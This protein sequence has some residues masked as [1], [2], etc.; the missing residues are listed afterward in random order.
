MLHASRWQ[1]LIIVAAFWTS[2]LSLDDSSAVSQG[3]VPEG[4]GTAPTSNT[5][6]SQ[7]AKLLAVR[8]VRQP[9]DFRP[10]YYAKIYSF[11]LYISL[12]MN[13]KSYCAEYTTQVL[14]EIADVSSAVGSEVPVSVRKKHVTITTPVGRHL[15][16]GLTKGS[17]CYAG[18]Q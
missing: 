13:Q 14:E 15:K 10:T 18:P 5:E 17:E 3:I 9:V 7:K 11:T 8:K 4:T 1:L 12:E 2:A 6:G 16:T